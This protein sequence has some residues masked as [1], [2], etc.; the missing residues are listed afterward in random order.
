M[1]IRW[2]DEPAVLRLKKGRDALRAGSVKEARNQ[3]VSTPRS[4]RPGPKAM[5]SRRHLRTPYLFMRILAIAFIGELLIMIAL[6]YLV[7][8]RLHSIFAAF[9]D[10]SLLT[11]LSSPFLWWFV[12]HPIQLY[13]DDRVGEVNSSLREKENR[14]N[15]AEHDWEE[16]FNSLTDM[17]TIHDR[18][19]NIIRTNKA[20]EKIL[21]LP[22]LVDTKA[23]CYAYFHGA[24]VS[25]ESCPSCM[26]L[27]TGRP[28]SFETFEPSLDKYIEI[29]AIPRFDRNNRINGLIHVVR[30]ITERKKMEEEMARSEGQLRTIIETV[31]ECVKLLDARGLLLEMNATGLAMIE[32]RTLDEIVGKPI[33]P[34]IVPEYRKSFE[35][36]TNR[37]FRGESGSLEFE[38][39]GLRGS[40]RWVETRAAPLKNIRGEITALLGVTRDVTEEKKLEGQL[41]HAQKMEAIGTLTGGIAHDF[42]NILTA[43]IGYGN[44]IKM[45]L[46]AADPLRS[47]AEQL[48]MS[49]ERAASL[50]QSLLAFSRKIVL[51]SKPVDLNG[52]VRRVEQLLHRLIGEDI[53]LKTELSGNTISAIAD[54]GQIEQVL[55]NLATNARDAMPTGGTLTISTSRVELDNDFI[56]THGY[57]KHGSYSLI[58]VAD[59]GVGMDEQTRSR[60]F[61]P[62]FTTKEV[63]KG[64]GLGLAIAYGIIKQ[65]NGFINC[66]STPCKGTTFRVY[67]PIA[68]TT[69]P[70]EDL[71]GKKTVIPSSGTET[72]LLAEDDP[73]V[74][75][76]TKTVLE[77]FGYTILE[78]GDGA[79]AVR[80]YRA[81]ENTVH[82]LLFDVVMPRMNGKEAY[83]EIRKMKPGI[84]SLFMSGYTNTAIE[85]KGISVGSLTC[86]LKPISPRDLLKKVREVLDR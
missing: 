57:G 13:A 5:D 53:E 50:T 23:D 20:A 18:D 64:T 69:I 84:K 56:N 59:T 38:M 34:F 19:F 74:R 75:R 45:K 9:L 65:H 22:F 37:V 2:E 77:D 6:P 31:P 80:E 3:S 46:P 4:Y 73:E 76:L 35:D 54:S 1:P 72:V 16:T 21:G 7:G 36:L 32:A 40:R 49:T 66:V 68:T 48:L 85:K 29:R 86:V 17:I 41:R 12:I 58:T 14:L 11:V 70:A 25:R 8:Q 26:A 55:M 30:D 10:A 82:L 81:H 15:Q 47:H 83:D 43:I 51:S 27:A 61:E 52:I 62:F 44:I 42:N 39:I 28:A 79:E 24:D 63:G 78:A 60:I 33:T 67:L 71:D